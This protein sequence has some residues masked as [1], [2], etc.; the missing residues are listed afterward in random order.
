MSDWT[1]PHGFGPDAKRGDC[2]ACNDEIAARSAP[3]SMN[4]DERAEEVRRLL[5]DPSAYRVSDIH[6]R[7]EALVGRPVWTHEF[8]TD[9]RLMEEARGVMPHPANL[10]DHAL[11]SLQAVIGDKPVI[12]VE[13]GS[14]HDES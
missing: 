3:E 10:H 5:H 13:R 11:S 14:R 7:L 6:E 2:G 1:C 9:T 12:V 8:V 4:G